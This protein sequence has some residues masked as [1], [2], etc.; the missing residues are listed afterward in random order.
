VTAATSAYV[1]AALCVAWGLAH[2]AATRPVVSGFETL[3]RSNRLTL[4][5]AWIGGG[6][7]LVFIGVLVALVTRSGGTGEAIV[8]IVYRTSG[9]MLLAMAVLML[10]TA[11]RTP[12]VPMKICPFIQT[13][14]AI[15]LL[16]AA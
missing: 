15:L 9:G 5:M 13:T 10:F 11:S 7:A 16:I 6:F 4:T 2:L 14:A 12:V 3:T 8:P 1:A